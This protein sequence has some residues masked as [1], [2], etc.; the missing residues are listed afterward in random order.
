MTIKTWWNGEPAVCRRL[1]VV[2]GKSSFPRPWSASLEHTVRQAV[3]VSYYGG[4]MYLDD[5]DGT[6]WEKVTEGRGLPTWPHRNLEVDQIV[7]EGSE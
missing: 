6:G 3:E 5:E 4:V 1:R 2:V 7:T